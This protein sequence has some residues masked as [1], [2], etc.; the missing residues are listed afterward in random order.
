MKLIKK[1]EKWTLYRKEEV[2]LLVHE[3]GE[4]KEFS[5]R[6]NAELYMKINT[7]NNRPLTPDESGFEDHYFWR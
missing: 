2:F 7:N 5:F 4:N 3:N 1:E 6:A